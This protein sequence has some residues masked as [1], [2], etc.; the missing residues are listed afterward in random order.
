MSIISSFSWD[1]IET[2]QTWA[3]IKMPRT[4]Y[5]PLTTYTCPGQGMFIKRDWVVFGSSALIEHVL[6]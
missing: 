5:L 1:R 2:S 6:E 3:V 4:L